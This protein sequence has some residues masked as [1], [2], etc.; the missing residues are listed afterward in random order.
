MKK[1]QIWDKKSNVFTPVGENLT[2]E[3]WIS[4]YGWIA[5]PV[6]VP[7]ISAGVINGAFIGEL[8]EMK[9]LYERMGAV[10][11][12]GISDEELLAEIEAWEDSMNAPSNEIST[13][14]RTA[15]ALEAQVM[16][17]MPDEEV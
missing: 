5:N 4:R 3:M 2:A 12:E 14:E 15:S 8:S 11:T 16:M 17:A 9:A 1:Y 13:D 6:A 10:F 7:V